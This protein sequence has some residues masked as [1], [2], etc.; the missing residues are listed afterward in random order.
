MGPGPLVSVC[1]GCRHRADKSGMGRKSGVGCRLHDAVRGGIR[2]AS[3]A[4]EG[5]KCG[6]RVAEAGWVL[7]S[8]LCAT[9]LIRDI[10]ER[11]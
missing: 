4:S 9:M 3:R 1:C 10:L 7:T 5:R 2:C 6:R 8:A 11:E